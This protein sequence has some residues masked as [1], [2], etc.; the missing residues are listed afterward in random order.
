MQNVWVQANVIDPNTGEEQTTN[1]FYFTWCRDE[2]ENLDR[3]VVPKT[4][5]GERSLPLS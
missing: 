4:Y 3:M 2:G 1:N 5:Q